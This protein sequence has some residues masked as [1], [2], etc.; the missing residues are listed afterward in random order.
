MLLRIG[1]NRQN[2]PR[3]VGQTHFMLAGGGGFEP[4]LTDPESAVLPLD[5][6]PALSILYHIP[7]ESTRSTN[8]FSAFC[9]RLSTRSLPKMLSVPKR[10]GATGLPVTATRMIPK[11]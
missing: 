7:P 1:G 6:P 4:P 3:R 8:A 10:G 9:M 5:D 11:S 2:H